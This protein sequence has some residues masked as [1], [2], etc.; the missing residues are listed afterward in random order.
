MV[1]HQ[2]LDALFPGTYLQWSGET[3][4]SGIAYARVIPTLCGLVGSYRSGYSIGTTSLLQIAIRIPSQVR[5]VQVYPTIFQQEF[6]SRSLIVSTAA[7][8][9]PYV[10]P[11]RTGQR[12]GMVQVVLVRRVYY[13]HPSLQAVSAPKMYVSPT[14]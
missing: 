11:G 2:E 10:I 13:S 12:V 7:Y 5:V 3:N 14:G 8:N 4:A 6:K 9:F 1:V